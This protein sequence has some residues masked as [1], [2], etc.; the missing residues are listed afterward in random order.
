[1]TSTDRAMVAEIEPMGAIDCH[2][3]VFDPTR[4]PYR[5]D[6]DY[7]PAGQESGDVE[8]DLAVLDAHRIGKALLVQPT[9]GYRD[10][11]RCLFDALTQAPGR[12]RGI[13]RIDP[14]AGTDGLRQLDAPGVCGIRIDLI[15]EGLGILQAARMPSLLAALEERR[16]V[17]QI[18]CERDQLADAM[19]Q[20][21]QLL[22]RRLRIVVDHCGRPDPAQPLSQR[23]FQALL[24]LGREGHFAKLSGPFRFSTRF[25]WIDTDRFVHAIL[26]AFT[27]GRCV[28]GSDWPFLRLNARIDYGPAMAVLDRWIPDLEARHQVLRETPRAL[29]G[30][31]DDSTPE[32]ARSAAPPPTGERAR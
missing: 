25:P 29:F 21:R 22:P 15:G 17:L 11:N 28:W 16:Q 18:Q 13:L 30:F 5:P 10:D 23:G 20:L 14:D 31:I 2:A 27:P 7:R 26:E 19:P 4:F 24:T 3:H 1:M 8:R 6:A 9:S 32:P 12:L